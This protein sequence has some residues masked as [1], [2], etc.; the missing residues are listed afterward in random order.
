MVVAALLFGT[1]WPSLVYRFREQP[2][3]STLDRASI[4]HNQAATLK[5][6]GLDQD[7]TTQEY[8]ATRDAPTRPRRWPAP[9]GRRRSGCST[10][11][12]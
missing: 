5:A 1:V 6:F 4:E 11:T 9:G 2:S 3:A 10:P 12:S 7:V 8:G